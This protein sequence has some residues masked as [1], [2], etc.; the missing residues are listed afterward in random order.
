VIGKWTTR[1]R[2]KNW[3]NTVDVDPVLYHC[4]N[5]ATLMN[6]NEKTLHCYYKSTA[7]PMH[8]QFYEIFNWKNKSTGKL[9][10]DHHKQMCYHPTDCTPMKYSH[11]KTYD[12]DNDNG[13]SPPNS[14]SIKFAYCRRIINDDLGFVQRF[15]DYTEF[16]TDYN[17]DN[18]KII[19]A[20]S[21]L[22]M[23]CTHTTTTLFFD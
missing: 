12:H 2:E 5:G 11:M 16:G 18:T 17:T 20:I 7:Y 9:L 3:Y 10:V 4:K 15:K 22:D 13:S 23:K 21:P 19:T 6:W 14:A 1:Y 8:R